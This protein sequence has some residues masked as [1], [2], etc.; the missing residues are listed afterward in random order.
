M[1]GQGFQALHG[2]GKPVAVRI[3]QKDVGIQHKGFFHFFSH[4]DYAH[5]HIGLRAAFARIGYA[6]SCEY[7]GISNVARIII[8]NHIYSFFNRSF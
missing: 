6:D 5:D 3:V 8:N 4:I 7:S 1:E 2:V